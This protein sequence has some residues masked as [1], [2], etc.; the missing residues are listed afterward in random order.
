MDGG[1]FKGPTNVYDV[2]LRCSYEA[3]HVDY[4]WFYGTIQN[5]TSIPA[6]NGTIS[7]LWH[8]RQS[9]FSVSGGNPTLQTILDQAAVQNSSIAFAQTWAD[10]YS[11]LAMATVGGVVSARANSLEQL[12]TPMLV[13]KVSIPAL[14]FLALCC[15]AFISAGCVLTVFAIQA[16]LRDDIRD[17]KARLTVFG[18]VAWA[19]ALA[20]SG[21]REDHAVA[22]VKEEEVKHEHEVVGLSKGL[23]N[24]FYLKV[25]HSDDGAGGCSCKQ[26]KLSA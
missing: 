3:L 13:V 24:N 7:E 25:F 17:A 2:V 26:E 20:S 21:G 6:P 10:L 16:V 5:L 9:P 23:L 11:P 19:V 15:L 12:R 8:G 22:L 18:I 1:F 4:T 14:A